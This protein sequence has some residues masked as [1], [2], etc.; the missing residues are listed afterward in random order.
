MSI[1]IL[2]G[3][4]FRYPWLTKCLET[5]DWKTFIPISS[6]LEV[7]ALAKINGCFQIYCPRVRDAANVTFL[8][9]CYR[10]RKLLVKMDTTT[11]NSTLN[12]KVNDSIQKVGSLDPLGPLNSLGPLGLLSPLSP[13]GSRNT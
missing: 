9:C 12:D 11:T 5:I 10:Q 6:N 7:R 13:L 8:I 3:R 1:G 2:K 4:E